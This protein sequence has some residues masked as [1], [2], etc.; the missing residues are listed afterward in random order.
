MQRYKAI[1]ERLGLDFKAEFR[2]VIGMARKNPNRFHSL[3]P[4]I[5]RANLDRFPYHCIYR[6]IPAGIRVILL[7]HHRRHPEFEIERE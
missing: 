4:G 1:S 6:E 7:R 2:R 3:K 5:H